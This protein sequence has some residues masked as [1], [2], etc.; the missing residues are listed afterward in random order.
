MKLENDIDKISCDFEDHND[1]VCIIALSNNIVQLVPI[2]IIIILKS[3]SASPISNL[4]MLGY[5]LRVQRF[6]EII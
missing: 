1:I 6:F 4:E 5:I 3:R 2:F